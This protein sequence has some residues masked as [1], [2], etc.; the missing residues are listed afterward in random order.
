VSFL[1]NLLLGIKTLTVNGTGIALPI[2]AVNPT[3]LNII[4]GTVAYNSTSKAWDMSIP[5][6]VLGSKLVG[7]FAEQN[8]FA[9]GRVEMDEW[10]KSGSNA[11]FGP[12]RVAEGLGADSYANATLFN[13][14][15]AAVSYTL[16]Q[17]ISPPPNVTGITLQADLRAGP[18]RVGDTVVLQLTDVTGVSVLGSVSCA[19]TSSW[20]T[21]STSIITVTPGTLYQVQLL[22]GGGAG[23]TSSSS[24]EVT[25]IR[26]QAT[27]TTN[28]LF[29]APYTRYQ[30]TGDM[31][32]DN[33]QQ[34]VT[35]LIETHSFPIRRQ[36]PMSK[37]AFWTN[38][39]L[40]GVQL[41]NLIT[42]GLA[43]AGYVGVR[44][45]GQ[46]L[47][48]IRGANNTA[49]VQNVTLP[50]NPAGSLNYVEIIAS[51]HTV[52]TGTGISAGDFVLSVIAPSSA[53]VLPI[54]PK[55][56]NY[57]VVV[58]GDSKTAGY[59]A[60]Y[61]VLS[62]LM[63]LWARNMTDASLVCD[64]W[65]GRHVSD[66]CLSYGGVQS[67]VARIAA[68]QPDLV[69]LSGWYRNDWALASLTPQQVAAEIS[70]FVDGLHA[71]C[72]NARFLMLT[73][74]PESSVGANGLGYTLANYGT[75]C[76]QNIQLA[77]ADWMDFYD[78]FNG[79]SG[80]VGWSSAC[81]SGD[82]IHPNDFGYYI[83]FNNTRPYLTETPT[84]AGVSQAKTTYYTAGVAGSG[85]TFARTVNTPASNEACILKVKAFLNDT[86]SHVSAAIVHYVRINNNAGTV[87]AGTPTVVFSD[88]ASISCTLAYSVSSGN[89][90]ATVTNNGAHACDVK[91]IVETDRIT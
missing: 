7:R 89:I 40:I 68:A 16:S 2:G 23:V 60:T 62:G 26:T 19:L 71:A 78:V 34:S 52:L 12:N 17:A 41:W 4:G 24:V 77:R 36:S 79:A 57:R 74:A 45:N 37:F 55:R 70:Q 32:A 69:V 28:P 72:P 51:D 18:A 46:D 31:L 59:Q 84:V 25:Q 83:I 86:T 44:V 39:T 38:A 80:P 49:D 88:I 11:F 10:T 85:G 91:I 6:A 50:S 13:E 9:L 8:T 15:N 33:A 56:P 47:T 76:A 42:A 22:Y 81:I 66:D 14:N 90:V 61:P 54:A 20:Q 87:T 82:G 27:T 30:I 67:F 21:F 48:P 3:I 1:D 58:I 53:V 43:N 73:T 5:S 63:G 65:S 29:T 64:C 35:T 75:E